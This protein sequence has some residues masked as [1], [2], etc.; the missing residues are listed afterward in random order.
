MPKNLRTIHPLKAF[1]V[2]L[3]AVTALG[4]AALAQTATPPDTGPAIV[5]QDTRGTADQR[6]DLIVKQLT[7]AEK[8]SLL[9]GTGFATRPIERLGIPALTMSDGPQGVRNSP[10]PMEG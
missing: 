8:V 10:T 3:A 7:Q 2:T 6:A 4:S 9:S 1:A 5:A